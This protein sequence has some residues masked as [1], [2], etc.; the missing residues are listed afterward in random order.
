MSELL[1]KQIHKSPKI[2]SLIQQLVDEVS[3][4]GSNIK[5]I[6]EPDEAL[7][8][9]AKKLFDEVAKYRGRPLFYPFL[10]TGAGHGVYVEVEDG[11]VKIDLINGIGIHIF[12]HSHPRILKASVRGALSDVVMQG[13]LEPGSEYATMGKKLVEL[14]SKK[15][16][17]KYAWL[18]TCGTMANE[19]ALKMARQKH[20]PAKMIMAMDHAFAGRS[21]AMAEITDNPNY[22]QGLPEYREVLRIPF[23][24]ANNPKSSEDSLRA[25]KEH[26]VLAF[27][28]LRWPDPK[29][30]P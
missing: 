5:S 22:R 4:V 18:S 7:A 24:D 26:V 19:N 6:R 30:R 8:D 17:L 25:M 20:S 12:G 2:E 29:P 21:Q 10:G 27:S 11:S 23:Y 28:S 16:R 1:G 14:A 15:S 3:S 9:H 13:N